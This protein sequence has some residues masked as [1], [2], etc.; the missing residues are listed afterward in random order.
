MSQTVE[1]GF[2]DW[3]GP[4]EAETE[5]KADWSFQSYFVFFTSQGR[6]TQIEKRLLNG[7]L[8]QVSIEHQD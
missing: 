4:K 5:G 1:V 8:L 6:E 7:S 3:K 2:I